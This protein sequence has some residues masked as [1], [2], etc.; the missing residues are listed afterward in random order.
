M[1]KGQRASTRK[2]NNSNLRAKFAPH[3]DARTERLSAKLQ[4]LAAQP[5]P[6]RDESMEVDEDQSKE[7]DKDAEDEDIDMQDTAKSNS[8]SM[9]ATKKRGPT[10]IQKK[11]ANRKAKKS[12]VFEKNS[13]KKKRL[14]S[15]LARKKS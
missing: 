11:I 4:E 3:Y 14:A 1:A 2:R 10:R 5:K 8:K 15:N 9:P 7:D 12:I 13:S 6:A